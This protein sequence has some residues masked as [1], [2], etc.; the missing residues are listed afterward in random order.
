MMGMTIEQIRA[1]IKDVNRELNEARDAAVAL[2]ADANAEPQARSDAA[3]K[4]NELKERRDILKAALDDEM[5]AQSANLKQIH[6]DMDQIRKAAGKFRNSGDFLSCVAKASGVNPVVDPRLAEYMSV[7]SDASGQN[8]TTDTEGGYLVPPDYADELLNV[9]ASE[10]ILFNEVTRIPVSGN[11]LIVNVLDQD[12]RKD[13]RA[14]DQSQSITEIKGRHGGLLAYWKG[15]AAELTA[16]LMRFKQDTT[17]L[18]KLTGLCYATEEMLED[19]PAM[20]AYI[21]REFADEFTFKIDDAILNGAGATYHQPIGVLNGTGNGALVTIAKESGQA[22]GTLVLNNILKMWNAMPARNRSNAKWYIN[23]DLEIL[24]YMILMNT[25][26]LSYTGT[27]GDGNAVELAGS[28]GYP[29]FVPAGSLAN[30]PHGMLLG[31][32][33]VPVEQAPA[34]GEAGDI[35]LLD[36]SQYRWIDKA[37]VNAQTSI[38]VRFLYD[39]TA[40][41][42]TY[43]CGGKPIWTDKI[44]AYSGSTKRSPYVALGARKS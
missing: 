43:R 25:G 6:G 37:G 21:A 34:V 32:P 24:L 35:S 20:S 18:E 10:S 9:A 4:L 16:S 23:Q 36:L 44:E 31:R 7:R 27:D 19:L 33:I 1:Q 29:I 26:S 14:A 3:A 13:Y 8:I 28:Y 5:E 42:F 41:R 30:A 39:E 11:R 12:S 2:A 15:E 17:V 40:F 22:N 38:H